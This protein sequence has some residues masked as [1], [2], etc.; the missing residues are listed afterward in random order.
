MGFLQFNKSE[1][2]QC[3]LDKT[4]TKVVQFEFGENVYED[5]VNYAYLNASIDDI[6][7]THNVDY[8]E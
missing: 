6:L 3:F 2:E 4:L 8:L 5:T 7:K 1:M